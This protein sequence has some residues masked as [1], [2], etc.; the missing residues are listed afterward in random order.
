LS[1]ALWFFIRVSDMAAFEAS[2]AG[3]SI[4]G[5]IPRCWKF[6]TAP[7]LLIMHLTLFK[8]EGGCLYWKL[9]GKVNYFF[10]SAKFKLKYKF[11]GGL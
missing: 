7:S 1:N 11:P 8:G 3:L 4:P 6:I 5:L 9:V 10:C 2:N